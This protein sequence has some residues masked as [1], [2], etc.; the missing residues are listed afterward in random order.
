MRLGLGFPFWIDQAVPL[1]MVVSGFVL[2]RETAPPSLFLGA[3]FGCWF[4]MRFHL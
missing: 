1:F 3:F 4:P 2:L